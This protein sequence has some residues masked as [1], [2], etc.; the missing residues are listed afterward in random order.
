M[1]IADLKRSTPG[2]REGV[3]DHPRITLNT[4]T[5]HFNSRPLGERFWSKV[6]KTRSCWLWTG[7]TFRDG[8]GQFSAMIE[9]SKKTLKAHRVSWELAHG[10]IPDGLCVLHRCDMRNCIRPDHLFLGTNIE[11]TADRDRKG[12]AASGD[13]HFSH[14]HPDRVPRGEKHGRAKITECDVVAIRKAYSRGNITQRALA[15]RFGI[16]ITQ[17]SS[18][19]RGEFWKHVGGPRTRAT[20]KSARRKVA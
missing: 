13:R 11:N 2:V 15:R 3:Q 14:L 5:P 7:G 16:T 4:R 12:R 20:R 9:G 10:S 18:I 1:A 6:R 19:V 17:V 8:Y